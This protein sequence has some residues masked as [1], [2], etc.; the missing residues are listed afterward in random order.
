[1]SGYGRTTHVSRTD[2]A[3]AVS[4]DLGLWHRLTVNLH[5]RRC[6]DCRARLQAYRLDRERLKEAALELPPGLNWDRLAAEMT[7]NIRVGLAA[8]ECVAPRR[9]KPAGFGWKPALAAAGVAAVLSLAWW[10]NLPASD[11]ASLGRAVRA[12]AQGHP[13]ADAPSFSGGLASSFGDQGPVVEASP[14]GVELRENGSS[15]GISQGDLRPLAV[16]VSAQGSASARYVDVD[17]GQVTIT[18]VYAQ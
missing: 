12:I 11:T 17:T 6:E 14:R 18:S 13:S 1:M 8:G 10:L 9:P 7:A 5:V 3:L 15:L 16:S 2:L 4:G